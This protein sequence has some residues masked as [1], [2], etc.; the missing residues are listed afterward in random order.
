MG[1]IWVK[2]FTGGLDARRLPETTPGGVLIRARDGHVTRGGEFEKRAAFVPDHTLPPGT[3]GLAADRLGLVV[4]G[5]DPSP[6]MPVGV[7]YQRLQHPDG[8]A[9]VSVPSYDLYNGK[10]YAVGVYADGSVHHFYDGVRVAD[11]FDGRARAAFDVRGG[12][13]SPA[14]TLT[15]LRVNGVP[16][17]SAPVVWAT[18]N[19][20]TASAIAAA[21]NSYSS[22]PEY[23]AVAVGET[24]NIVAATSGPGP[25]G[26][27]VT[28]SVADGLVLSPAT[29]LVLAGGDTAGGSPASASFDFRFLTPAA[30]PT[31]TT[32]I[33]VNGVALTAAPVA[34]GI[35][36]W[37]AATAMAAA[38]NAHTSTPNYTAVATQ[39]RVVITTAD[40][41]SAVNG[42]SPTFEFTGLAPAGGTI[43]TA[44]FDI[45]GVQSTTV[46]PP[47]QSNDNPITT[48]PT[49]LPKVNGVALTAVPVNLQPASGPIA[50][51]DQ[52]AAA[53]AAAINAHTSAPNYT[54]TVSGARVTVRTATQTDDVNG[55]SVAFETTGVV[56]I[57]GNTA[58][59]GGA[60]PQPNGSIVTNITP[61]E[62]GGDD[63]AFVPGTFVRT[64]KSKM[65]A[66]S[67]SILHFSGIQAPTR[68]TTDAAGAGFINLATQNSGSEVLT[69][70]ARYQNLLAVFS[71]DVVQVWFV[72]P[73]P[74]L[75]TVSQVLA[76]TGTLAPRSVTEFGDSDVFYLDG[77]GLRSLRARDSSNSAATTDIGVPIDDLLVAKIADMPE[78]E[79]RN[80]IG[81]INPVDKRFWLILKDEIFVFSYYQNAK[82]SAWTTYSTTAIVDGNP[83]AFEVQDAVVFG[84]RPWLRAG[85]VLFVYGGASGPLVYD[86][87]EAE[88]WLPYL[89]ANR[90]TA[91]K[92][93]TGID[94]AL[95]GLWE[96]KAAT[97]PTDLAA[98]EVVARVYETTYNLNRLPYWHTSSHLSLRLTSKGA[99]RA[100]L[101]AL[102]LHFEGREEET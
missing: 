67:G 83:L 61:F 45:A 18:S 1:T 21:I 84:G 94:A 100:V 91:H 70:V 55:L 42:L 24:V 36:A 93:W 53:I 74:N 76:N 48:W 26:L 58:F 102:A 13:A 11:W 17:I 15:D 51:T 27:A 31:A 43:A 78:T 2:E 97:Q 96:V 12:T 59:S 19:E 90:P 5:S 89:D 98:A 38:I 65:Y 4:F 37:A 44:R 14:S 10:I 86:E 39:A 87:A 77:S 79:R 46:E 64:V 40:N 69:A 80:V 101:S 35:G 16:I 7:R 49:L 25:N 63:D 60:D 47:G 28:P 92:N 73:D 81:L 54:A 50:A 32:L 34:Y 68:W 99:G 41:T 30:P 29:G 72:D 57:T 9:L 20:A 82:V 66:T 75:N 23:T 3:L 88:A 33:R 56:T 62:G 95:T 71:P 52:A 8:A 22:S 85:D 6:I